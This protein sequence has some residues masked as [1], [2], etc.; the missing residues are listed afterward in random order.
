M[1]WDMVRP[2]D[3]MLARA[4]RNGIDAI[5]QQDVDILWKHRRRAVTLVD[6]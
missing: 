3:V 1:P 2:G 6:E 4:Q 5:H